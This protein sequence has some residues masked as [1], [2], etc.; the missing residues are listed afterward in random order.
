MEDEVVDFV[1]AMHDSEA[2]F[3]LVREVVFVP[4]DHFVIVGDRPDGDFGLYVDGFGLCLG[5]SGR[6]RW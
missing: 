1:V 2:C 3:T 6:Q 4:S 5:Y